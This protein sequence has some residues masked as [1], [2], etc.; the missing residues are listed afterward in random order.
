[1]IAEALDTLWTLLLA[2][3]AWLLGL[4]LAATAALYACAVAVAVACRWAWR[5]LRAA[6]KALRRAHTAP[7]DSRDATHAPEPAD[8]RTAP[9]VPTWAQTDKEAA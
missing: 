7:R 3:G 1:M 2:G 9:R 6:W 5:A 4:A 8:A